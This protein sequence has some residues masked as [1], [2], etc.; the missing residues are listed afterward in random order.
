MGKSSKKS[1]ISDTIRSNPVWHNP[2]LKNMY[3]KLRY[4]KPYISKNVQMA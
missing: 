1:Q 3:I 2:D 4:E